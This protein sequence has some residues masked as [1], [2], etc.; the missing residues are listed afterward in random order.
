MTNQDKRVNLLIIVPL[1]VTVLVVGLGVTYALFTKSVNS[2]KIISVASGTKYIGIYGEGKNNL[3]IGN[4]YTFTVENRGVED[5]GYE[6]YI[7]TDSSSTIAA[8]NVTCE[9]TSTSKTQ[10]TANVTADNS[11]LITGNL[12]AGEQDTITIKLSGATTGIYKGKLKV[13]Y[14]EYV[15]KDASG[16][17][18]PQLV[19]GMIP[20]VYDESN[21]TWK[22]SSTSGGVWY[23]YNNQMWANAVTIKDSTKRTIYQNADIGTP[24]TI[25]DINTFMVWIP[26]YSYTLGNT[27]GY[28]IEGASTPSKQT[29]GAFDIKFVNKNTIDV[30]SGQY[31]GSTPENYFTPSSFCWG[32]TCDDEATR[33]DSGNIE[34]E[35]IWIAK[36][37]MSGTLSNIASVPNATSITNQKLSSYFTSIQNNMN[38]SL[39]NSNYGLEGNYDTH[40]IKNTEWG[41]MAYLS[42]SKY[43][44]YGN[45][46][47]SGLNKEIYQNK[48]KPYSTGKS[49]GTPG[50]TNKNVQVAYNVSNT[51]TGASTTGNIY[52]IYDTSGGATELVMGNKKNYSGIN[53]NYNSG[54]SGI[55]SDNGSSFSGISF[56]SRKYYNLYSSDVLNESNSIKGDAYGIDGTNGFYGD[57]YLQYACPWIGRGG[58]TE[59]SGLY[60]G[61]F[62]FNCKNG[63]AYAQESSRFSLVYID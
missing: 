51:G 38:G 24:I 58:G 28:Q 54:F 4:T 41:A 10:S 5:S 7:E 63:A 34:L 27:Y 57:F 16:A 40:M 39:G 12:K 11:I 23:D 56:P 53:S 44:K 36:F 17:N 60:A 52:G 13:R 29:P 2:N 14:Q 32:D 43:G 1:L 35:G 62:F 21:S 26:R 30:G 59:S 15:Q 42:Q 55:L 48:S 47:Y 25:S 20:V 46:N 50:Q 18:M 33:K 8:S 3:Q 19:N 22:K 61:I 37:E 49:N 6:L 45:P 9:I 31:T